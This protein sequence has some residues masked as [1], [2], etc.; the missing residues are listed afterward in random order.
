MADRIG[1]DD[2]AVVVTAAFDQA[3]SR[4]PHHPRP[5]IVLVDGAD[6]QI[7]L[8]HAEAARRAVTVHIVIDIVHVIEKLWA[9]SRCFYTA[10]DPAAET[11]VATHAA[12]LLNGRAGDVITAIGTQ[13]DRRNLTK[14]QRSAA[15][16]ACRYLRTRRTTSA[17]TP[18]SPKAGPSP[19]EPSREP[20][21]T[22]S[23]TA[24]RSQDHGGASPAPK[25]SSPCERSS[26]TATSTSTGGST[27]REHQ[28][29]YPGT[30]QGQYTLSA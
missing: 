27:A 24:W 5:W 16:A 29:L 6:H 9:A 2:P 8:I 30:T 10:T 28:R 23:P 25:P 15:D 13:A 20:A 12:A 18:P 21:G 4:D 22:S 19:A 7:D 3:E 11:W 1:R 26:A 17:T 14:D